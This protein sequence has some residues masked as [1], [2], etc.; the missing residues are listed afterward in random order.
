[1]GRPPLALLS[2]L[3][4]A[5]SGLPGI[6]RAIRRLR[7]GCTTTCGQVRG[8]GEAIGAVSQPRRLVAPAYRQRRHPVN[9]VAVD[10]HARVLS[11]DEVLALL[12]EP[13]PLR[14]GMVEEDG[15]PLVHPVWHVFDGGVFRV[16]VGRTSRKAKVLRDSQRAYFT[17]DTTSG[18]RARG[19]RGRANVRV[20]DGDTGLAV[21]VCRQELLKYTRTDK[22]SFAEEMLKWAGSGDMSVVEL[23]P[24]RFGAFT[25]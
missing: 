25:Y 9:I 13:L 17:V 11:Q 4:H 3:R 18:E 23:R 24:V 10:P 5:T 7:D 22:G 14:L 21:E 2:G 1:M 12:A 15:W 20:I 6:L 19:V 8:A 16:L